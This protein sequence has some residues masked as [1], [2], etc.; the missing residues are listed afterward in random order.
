VARPLVASNSFVG[1]FSAVHQGRGYSK[2]TRTIEVTLGE[3]HYYSGGQYHDGEQYE[4]HF[5]SIEDARLVANAILAEV[6]HVKAH[7]RLLLGR[8]QDEGH[9]RV[10]SRYGTW[11][12][13]ARV[14]SAA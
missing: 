10:A 1:S 9:D 13:D 8:A 2:P 3:R 7:V 11:A 14:E 4:F 6:R 12:T 5:D